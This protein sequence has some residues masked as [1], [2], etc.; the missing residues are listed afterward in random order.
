MHYLTPASKNLEGRYLPVDRYFPV[1]SVQLTVYILQMMNIITRPFCSPLP[2]VLSGS[3]TDCYQNVIFTQKFLFGSLGFSIPERCLKLPA[4]SLA[5]SL[6][7]A[8]GSL[9]V[10]SEGTRGALYP[11]LCFDYHSPGVTLTP[12]L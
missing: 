9:A 10:L 12:F 3:K 5:R 2:R 11:T 7:S 6:G 8:D 1:P 4:Q